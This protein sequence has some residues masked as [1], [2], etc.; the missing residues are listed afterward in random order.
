MEMMRRWGLGLLCCALA[1]VTACGDEESDGGGD[2]NSATNNAANNANSANNGENNANNGDNSA[3]NNSDIVREVTFPIGF[4]LRNRAEIP[5]VEPGGDYMIMAS[6][7]SQSVKVNPDGVQCNIGCR[8]SDD[9]QWFFYYEQE[10]LDT[11]LKAAPVT[12]LSYTGAMVD[13]GR[14]EEVVTNPLA[15]RWGGDTIAFETGDFEI[16]AG[17]IPGSNAVS[18]GSVGDAGSTQGGFY[19][20]DDG[21]ALVT[22]T[23]T[24]Q[25]LTLSRF[26]IGTGDSVE[27]FYTYESTGFGGTGSFYSSSDRMSWS[28]DGKYLATVSVGLVDTD[29]CASNDQCAE[30]EICGNNARCT[31]QRLTLNMIELEKADKLA[32]PCTSDADCGDAHFCDFADPADPDSGKCLPGRLDLGAAGPQSC[33]L[34]QEGEYTDLLDNLQWSPDSSSL[35]FL[36]ATDCDGLANIPLTGIYRTTP[37]LD[38]PEALLVNEGSDFSV[39]SCYDEAEQEFVAERESCVVEVTSLALSRNGQT[40]VFSA[41]SPEA[42]SA[43]RYDL[44][45]IDRKGSRP[46]KWFRSGDI[47]KTV[48]QLQPLADF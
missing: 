32:Q 37:K 35:Y 10:G 1:L 42:S 29:P 27:G 2:A 45:T 43:N 44:F 47:F 9:L 13:V 30:G 19:L 24:L 6:D 16:F 8:L 40:L 46:K 15:V 17:P 41:T 5:D 11:V 20:K 39:G 25:S 12:A 22:W 4:V 14:A 33:A 18:Y 38:A 21:S 26:D 34:R 36:A 23:V 48:E 3:N 28:P 31:S 7:G